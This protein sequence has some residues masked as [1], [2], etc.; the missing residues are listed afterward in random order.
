MDSIAEKIIPINKQQELAVS[1]IINFIK[2]GDSTEW[3]TLEGKAGT[4]KTTIITSAIESFVGKK[5]IFICA[6]SHKAKKVLWDK[7]KMN[8]GDSPL[9]IVSYSVAALLGMSFNIETGKFTKNYTK[10]KAPIKMADIIIVDECSMIN[11][12]AL[13]LIMSEKKK[14]TKVIFVGDVG[15]L[16]PIRD[17]HENAGEISPVFKTTN[18]VSLFDRVRQ[19]ADS[20][21]L[22]YS[23]FYW[24]NSVVNEI[25]DEDP[26]PLEYRVSGRDIIFSKDLEKTI[27]NNKNLFIESIEKN[28]PNIIKVIVYRNKTKKMLNWFIRKLIYNEPKEYEL[29]D[30]L[31]INDNYYNGD[32]VLIIENSTEVSILQIKPV[33]FYN[34]YNGYTLHVTDGEAHYDL[35][36]ISETSLDDWNK[37]ISELFI[38]AKKEPF[39]RSRNNLLKKAWSAK[40]RFVDVDYAY[41]LSSHKSQ[42]STYETVIVFEDDIMDVGMIGEVEKSQSMYVSITRASKKV[43]IVSEFN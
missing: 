5:R 37:H 12:E 26:V 13:S 17:T 40:K 27:L 42:G 10:K 8:Y 29:G 15:Q 32:D 24:D 23:D 31:I 18:K 43:Y 20:D 22:K 25:P 1:E 16:P 3:F 2:K 14:N 36:V 34:K 4:G 21:I 28:N 41:T 9:G 6:L 11:E 35:D 33:K 38:K 30:L 7:V 19:S 39:G